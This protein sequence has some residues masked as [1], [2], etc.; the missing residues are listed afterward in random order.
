MFTVA[1]GNDRS[2]AHTITI[3][4]NDAIAPG[5]PTGLKA[6]P[7]SPTVIQL[8]WT[9]PENVGSFSITGYRVEASENTGGPWVVVAAD[10]PQHPPQLGPWRAVGR[11]HA[12]LPGVG[13]QPRGHV[14]PL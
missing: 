11:R 4:D 10:T 8:S 6:T 1:L 14:G 12:A 2:P 7:R 13:D 9:A 3:R 5:R